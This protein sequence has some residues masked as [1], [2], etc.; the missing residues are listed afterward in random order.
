MGRLSTHTHAGESGETKLIHRKQ[1]L[2]LVRAAR[3]NG[4]TRAQ[5]E[6]Q[7]SGDFDRATVHEVLPGLLDEIE[8]RGEAVRGDS[9]RT[10]ALEFT[11]Y[12]AGELRLTSRGFGVV[13][14]GERDLP[15]IVVPPEKL[16]TA[17][18]GDQVLVHRPMR[19][20][21]G[22]L[23]AEKFGQIV[24]VLRRRRPT[25]VGR[26]VA[27]PDGPWVDPFARR[28]K[29][30]VL[31]DPVPDVLPR[32]GE[33]VEVAVGEIPEVGEVTGRL[34][35]CLGSS[36]EPGVDEEVILAELAIPVAF[37]PEA[38][39]EA[40]DLPAGVRS[41]DRV[42]RVDRRDQAA[43]TIDGETA[44]DFDDAVVALPA[45][46]GDI[47][48]FV[49]IADVSH[50]VRPGHALDGA[51]R[52]RG[53]SVYL[54][55][56]CVPM[57]PERL[58]N[59]LCSLLPG[60]DRLAFTVRFL[61]KPNGAVEGYR[62]EKAVFRSRRRCTYT[63]VFDW[64]ERGQWPADI[65]PEVRRSVELLDEAAVRIG[66]RR[67][68]RGAI[69]FDLP[70]PEILLDPEGFMTGVQ[71]APRNRAHRLIEEL[72]VSANE[73]VARMLVWGGQ[74]GLFRVHERPS[75]GKLAELQAVLV[76]FGLALKGDLEELPPRAL[77]RV[78]AQIEKAPEERFLQTL[79]L[80]ALA[81]ARYLPSC[82]GHYAL[83]TDFYL[84]FT[85]PIRRYPDLVVH[86]L[87]G[88]M[89]AGRVRQGAERALA[90][91]DL[92][93]LAPQCSL[94]ER[95][96]EE[97]ERE[98]VKWKQTEYMRAHVGEEFVGH[99]TG[100]VAFGVFVQLAEVFVEGLIHVAELRDDYYRYDEA[101]HRLVGQRHGGVLR[102]GDELR[103][104]VR[105]IDEEFMEVDLEPVAVGPPAK[106]P[107][108]PTG[109][110]GKQKARPLRRRQSAG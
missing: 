28:L 109:L 39:Q 41:G 49:H 8:A 92:E 70:E 108:R 13:R 17:L 96:A 103:V 88:E 52:E 11:D 24:R 38:L 61:V 50:Y 75:P 94:T 79:V 71:A 101:G 69:D 80:R 5:L 16:G 27:D 78:L 65:A 51:A 42:G 58:S 91:A 33:F 66:A 14:A 26:F 1:V 74:L 45:D 54:P 64:V 87:L 25:L 23:V 106:R 86:R 44:R 9:G 68:A 3:G 95:R 7:L 21:R 97:A 2:D 20:K 30:K 15:D 36:G 22:Q 98:V 10:V 99:V 89:L 90:E 107:A 60:E 46:Q 48:V 82:K 76:E 6:R 63:E 40:E 84:H 47:E 81:R 85:S 104:R 59:Q 29:M 55:G 56:R 105:G 19:R 67:R 93:E 32:A 35:R 83:A 100:V 31:L 62:A 34:L 73:C 102:L 4:L 77:Q 57:L 72:M 18:D 37:S 43:V 12:W 110:R 53:T